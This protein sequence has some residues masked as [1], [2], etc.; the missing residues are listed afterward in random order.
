MSD[1]GHFSSYEG[2]KERRTGK[3]REDFSRVHRALDGR[4]LA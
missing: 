2:H 4:M 3:F 1:L